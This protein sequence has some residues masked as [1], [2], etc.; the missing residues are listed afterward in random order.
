MRRKPGPACRNTSR[1]AWRPRPKSSKRGH[2]RP[3]LTLGGQGHSKADVIAPTIGVAHAP[4]RAAQVTRLVAVKRPTPQH[5][6][7]RQ[8]ARLAAISLN[9]GVG[10]VSTAYPLLHCTRQVQHAIAT[11][12]VG[13]GTHW[14]CPCRVTVQEKI[15]ASPIRHLSTHGQVL[16]SVPRAVFS[17]SASVGRRTPAQAQKACASCQSTYTAG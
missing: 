3:C 4:G 15:G 10:S 17:H 16:P 2:R 7:L 8:A 6:L 1:T 11:R 14:P 13:I 5:A 9:I 12:A